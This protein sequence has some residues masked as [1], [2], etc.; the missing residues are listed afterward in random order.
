MIGSV[1]SRDNGPGSF[2]PAG[3]SVYKANG[4]YS[5]RRA[6]MTGSNMLV[7]SSCDGLCHRRLCLGCLYPL[8]NHYVVSS[9]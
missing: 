5:A 9:C 2:S 7:G 8:N 3:E 4:L 6:H 1:E